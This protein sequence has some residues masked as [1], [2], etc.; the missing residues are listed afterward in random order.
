MSTIKFSILTIFEFEELFVAGI[1]DRG[2]IIEVDTKNLIP[3]VLRAIL[4]L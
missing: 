4:K 1:Y 3:S 2:G